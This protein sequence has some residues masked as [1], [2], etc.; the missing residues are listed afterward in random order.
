MF[1]QFIYCSF[2]FLD[3]EVE[4]LNELKA[5]KMKILVLKKQNEFD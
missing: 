2:N 1:A 3:V 4:G 5:S